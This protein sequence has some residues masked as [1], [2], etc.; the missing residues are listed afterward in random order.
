M[1]NLMTGLVAEGIQVDL[2]IGSRE[3]A[4]LV[5][6]GAEVQ[7]YPVAGRGL[8][9]WF[10][11]RRYLAA[12]APDAVV[13]NKEWANRALALMGR[14]VGTRV[15]F[16]VGTN[17]SV[18]LAR[19]HPLKRWLRQRSIRW[20]YGRADLIVT[21]SKGVAEDVVR[22]AEVN[23]IK[24]KVLPNPTVPGD[25]GRRLE[26][27]VEHPWLVDKSAPVLVAVGR[28]SRPKDYPTLIHACVAVA[29]RRAIRLIILGEG[30]ERSRLERLIAHHDAEQYIDLHG[31]VSNPYPYLARA[32]LFVMSSVWEGMPNA[33]IEALAAGT[34]VVATD[35][36]HGPREVLA[37]GRYGALVPMGDP[38]RL[39]EAIERTLQS[40][41]PADVLREAARP[42]G[43]TA[44]S[45][46]YGQA[47][48][49]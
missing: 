15:V 8:Q 48:L 4:D 29:Q 36:P 45:R 6:L 30:G 1:L 47:I 10:R 25:L 37:E 43:V 20:A 22:V 2:L 18:Q 38:A 33:L 21:N 19:R 28:L 14:T 44:A 13:C 46:A 7:V 34:P 5:D 23:P 40:P 3:A 16:R 24:V 17:L 27:P 35:C 26:A 42:F 41:L 12:T 11:L 49:G 32:D 39:A 31:Y 9:A